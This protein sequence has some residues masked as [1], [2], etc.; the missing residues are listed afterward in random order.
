MGFAIYI[1][2]LA[3]VD[4]RL[5]H[6][7]DDARLLVGATGVAEV[8]DWD[9]AQAAA[10]D[11]QPGRRG[12]GA[13]QPLRAKRRFDRL[14]VVQLSGLEL[15]AVELVRRELADQVVKAPR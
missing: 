7:R 6:V 8:R 4:E 9:I 2:P 10:A 11:G 15:A 14:A 3:G 13:K 5:G 1:C 12:R